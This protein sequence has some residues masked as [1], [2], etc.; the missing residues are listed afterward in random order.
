M[1]VSET[2]RAVRLLKQGG[3][4]QLTQAVSSAGPAPVVTAC[5]RHPCGTEYTLFC[6]LPAPFIFFPATRAVF[7]NVCWPMSLQSHLEQTKLPTVYLVPHGLAPAAL[8]F[9]VSRPWLR[10]CPECAT[11]APALGPQRQLWAYS[12]LSL[13]F[14]A[15]DILIS[16]IQ[17]TPSL[18]WGLSGLA[19]LCQS[20]D[21]H[22]GTS[23]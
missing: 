12:S 6:Y 3:R 1:H 4:G 22:R 15:W 13:T 18:L 5:H 19:E 8:C 10:S 9:S 17:A 7:K 14:C 21:H 20:L 11:L 23:L 16:E 2:V